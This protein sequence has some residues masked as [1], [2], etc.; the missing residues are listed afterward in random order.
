MSF[1]CLVCFKILNNSNSD[2][3]K[4]IAT[5]LFYVQFVKCAVKINR[6]ISLTTV[7]SGHVRFYFENTV[8]STCETD[9]RCFDVVKREHWLEPRAAGATRRLSSRIR[10]L[11]KQKE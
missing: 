11:K 8:G 10:A 1:L 2:N 5:F 6:N 9:Y 7:V 3:N 4:Q